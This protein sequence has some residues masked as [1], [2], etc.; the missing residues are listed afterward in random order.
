MEVC[1]V[2]TVLINQQGPLD[3]H[4]STA[5]KQSKMSPI[6]LATW[7]VRTLYQAG[8]LEN[9]KQELQALDIEILGVCETR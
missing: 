9:L 8:K 4:P 5:V 2:E 3:R 6:K 1:P 7:N